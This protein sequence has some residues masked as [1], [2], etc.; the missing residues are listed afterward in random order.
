MNEGGQRA[1]I[2]EHIKVKIPQF[3]LDAF[4]TYMDEVEVWREV[5]GIPKEKQGL[6]LWLELP[7][8]HPSDIKELIMN[9]IGRDEL[10][11]ETGIEKFVEAMIKHLNLLLK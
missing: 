4:K 3:S 2:M 5:C 1:V 10:K 7:R 6:L 9:K 8:E 11:L